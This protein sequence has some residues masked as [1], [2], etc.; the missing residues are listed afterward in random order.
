[1]A[2]QGLDPQPLWIRYSPNC[3]DI[4]SIR[5]R[6]NAIRTVFGKKLRRP[7]ATFARVAGAGGTRYTGRPFS[8]KPLPEDCPWPQRLPNRPRHPKS[9]P[10]RSAD[11]SAASALDRI[12][13]HPYPGRRRSDVLAALEPRGAAVRTH[14]RRPVEK[15]MGTANRFSG[16]SDRGCSTASSARVTLGVTGEAGTM[17]SWRSRADA[18]RGVHPLGPHAPIA[19]APRADSDLPRAWPSKSSAS[20]TRPRRWTETSAEMS[21]RRVQLG[22]GSSPRATVEVTRRRFRSISAPC[23]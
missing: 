3:S 8:P 1:V 13:F 16:V 6:G 21:T 7:F 10:G 18:G 14:R 19:A 9:K 4:R 11:P 23:Y 17:R 20:V 22:D 15:A 2:S 12:R 5:A